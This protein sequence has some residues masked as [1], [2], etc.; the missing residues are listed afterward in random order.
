[1]TIPLQRKV[2]LSSQISAFRSL[3]PRDQAITPARPIESPFN[4]LRTGGPRIIRP[5]SRIDWSALYYP[6]PHVV[7]GIARD[8][9]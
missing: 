4:V 3:A 1:M 9:D 8:P 6:I 5:S 7:S 2:I